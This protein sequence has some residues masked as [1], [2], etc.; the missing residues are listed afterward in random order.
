[1]YKRNNFRIL[2]IIKSILFGIWESIVP[3]IIA[4]VIVSSVSQDIGYY[5]FII[6][7]F[8]IIWTFTFVLI[9][10]HLRYHEI[11]QL[12]FAFPLTLTLLFILFGFSHFHKWYYFVF[13]IVIILLISHFLTKFVTSYFKYTFKIKKINNTEYIDKIL[14]NDKIKTKKQDIHDSNA[15][16]F[17]EHFI[18]KENH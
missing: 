9:F 11:N 1:M 16:E 6:L 12:S 10:T 15:L 3:I 7:F 8:S 14:S 4:I 18:G 17:V 13:G 2:N 5:W